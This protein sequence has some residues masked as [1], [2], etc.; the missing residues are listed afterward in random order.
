MGF[1]GNFP[2]RKVLSLLMVQKKNHLKI[3]KYLPLK[4]LLIKV[5][6]QVEQKLVSNQ[7]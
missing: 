5:I 2:K 7:H 6:I 1:I 3:R 4:I